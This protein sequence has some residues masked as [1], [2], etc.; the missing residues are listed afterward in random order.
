MTGNVPAST[1]FDH[2]YYECFLNR[3]KTLIA[4]TSCPH[5]IELSKTYIGKVG[6]KAAEKSLDGVKDYYAKD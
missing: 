3:Y 1:S 5:I 2:K 4:I 6:I